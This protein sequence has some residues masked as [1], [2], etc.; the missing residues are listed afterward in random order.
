M[1]PFRD[2]LNLGCL[3]GIEPTTSGTTTRR[4]NQLSYKHHEQG[5]LYMMHRCFSI[6]TEYTKKAY[7]W[8]HLPDVLRTECYQ[9]IIQI[10][11][12][13]RIAKEYLG[14]GLPEMGLAA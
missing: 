1:T 12:E 13:L 7:A 10:S 6:V 2:H 3:M 8:Y 9:A 4:S 5:S 11:K 14:N